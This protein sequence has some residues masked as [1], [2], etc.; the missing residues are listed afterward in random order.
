[1]LAQLLGNP[2]V[3]CQIIRSILYFGLTCSALCQAPPTPVYGDACPHWGV[4]T[5]GFP[6][7]ECALRVN[8][9]QWGLPAVGTT[10]WGGCTLPSGDSQLGK[11][12][13]TED[14]PPQMLFRGRNVKPNILHVQ[15]QGG[16][17]LM[18]RVWKMLKVL[19]CLF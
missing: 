12:T 11:C 16:E 7:D 3:C 9:R 10:H 8:T 1:M 18:S 2:Q 19:L 17:H 13:P 14:C 4:Y 5:P 6:T 15:P